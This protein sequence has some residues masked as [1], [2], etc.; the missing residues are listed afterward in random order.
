VEA[1]VFLP[2][3][4][5]YI[6]LAEEAAAL[7]ESLANNHGFLDGNKRIAYAAAD[8]FLRIDGFFLDV[9]SDEAYDFITGSMDH[10]EFKFARIV[11]WI[12]DD[13]KKLA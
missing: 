13:R 4:G 5:Y 2:Q 1:A 11:H 9:I 6:S 7:M 10:R 3:T 8:T 12:R